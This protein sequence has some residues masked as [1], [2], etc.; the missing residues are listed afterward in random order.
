[1]QL[2]FENGNVLNWIIRNDSA[3]N[4]FND[5]FFIPMGLFNAS[6]TPSDFVMPQCSFAQNFK[7]FIAF[8]TGIAL[9]LAGFIF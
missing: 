4:T 5:A 9:A 6:F 7:N 2:Y 1:M 8:G 3:S